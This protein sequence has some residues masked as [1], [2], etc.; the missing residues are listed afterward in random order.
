[1]RFFQPFRDYK[2]GKEHALRTAEAELWRL[3]EGGPGA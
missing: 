2:H 3:L 1:V